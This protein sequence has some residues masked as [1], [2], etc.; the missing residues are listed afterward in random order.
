MSDYLVLGGAMLLNAAGFAWL[1]LAMNAHWKQVRG[2]PRPSRG[3]RILLRLGAGMAFLIALLLCNLSDHATIAALV[4]VMALTAGALLV[5][6]TLTWR[7]SW[8]RPLS[9]LGGFAGG[10]RDGP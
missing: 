8:L 6:F 1:A 7:P 5:A 4:W 9:W 10:N 2:S 3:G